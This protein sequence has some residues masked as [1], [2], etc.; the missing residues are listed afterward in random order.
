MNNTVSMYFVFLNIKKSRDQK[1]YAVKAVLFCL[2]VTKR[3]DQKK[4][5]CAKLILICCFELQFFISLEQKQ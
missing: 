1:K 2:H 3:Y 4:Y 5:K